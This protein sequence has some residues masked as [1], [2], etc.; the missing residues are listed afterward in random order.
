MWYVLV[1]QVFMEE[2]EQAMVLIRSLVDA[3]CDLN[4]PN[5]HGERPLYQSACGGTTGMCT[6]LP[7]CSMAYL[8][9]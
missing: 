3:G 2:T 5:Q 8:S 7:L 9:T 1:S 4:K 6:V